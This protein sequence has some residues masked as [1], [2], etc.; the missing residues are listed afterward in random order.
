MTIEQNVRNL[1]QRI[2]RACEKAGRSPDEVTLVAVTKTVDAAAIETA[3]NADVRD[4]G[5]SRVQEA[6][7]KIEQLQRLKPGITW[8]M[9]GHLQTNKARTAADIFDIIHSVDSLKLAETLNDCSPKRLPILIQVNVSAETT[10]GGF[11]LSE[12]NEA[13][14]QIGRLPNLEIQ[15]LMTIAPWVDNAE[16][17]RPIFRQMRQLRNALG[18]R[19][20]SMGMSDDFEVAIEEGATLVRIGRAIFGERS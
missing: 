16:E 9:L 10:K 7:P 20:L 14:R 15:G 8:H 13:V 1:Q 3:F 12:V 11:A 19:H 2:A 5:E 6:K 18:L 17:V 4:F